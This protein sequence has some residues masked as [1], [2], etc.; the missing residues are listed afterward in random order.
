MVLIISEPD[1]V[2]SACTQIAKPSR[3]NKSV[4]ARS[5]STLSELRHIATAPP[6]ALPSQ[7]STQLVAEADDRGLPTFEHT[8]SRLVLQS[9]RL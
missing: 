9:I 3:R 6:Q 2:E 5:F 7:E 8:G 4:V 1:L